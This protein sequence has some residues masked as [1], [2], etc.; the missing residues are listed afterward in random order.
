MVASHSHKHQAL[1]LCM[2]FSICAHTQ[3][4][5]EIYDCVQYQQVL[6]AGKE[7]RSCFWC[8]TS[9]CS[10]RLWVSNRRVAR[11][12]VAI[13]SLLCVTK[14]V[15]TLGLFCLLF[16]HLS[17][18]LDVSTRDSWRTALWS[19]SLGEWARM[20]AVTQHDFHAT[21]EDELSFQKS[22]IIKVYFRLCCCRHWQCTDPDHWSV[23]RYWWWMK[24]KAGL[25]LSRMA[26]LATYRRTT[27]SSSLIRK[28]LAM[29]CT[30]I[31]HVGHV[32]THENDVSD[33][34]N[35]FTFFD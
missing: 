3:D 8:S 4:K 24:N 11:A 17:C 9:E 29:C 10:S 22:S 16:I 34:S 18:D 27:S 13:R 33:L 26:V 25:K 14:K 7:T 31:S 20:E 1:L 23:C 6:C 32:T 2:L 15:F 35:S 19:N 21:A 28:C 12:R 30:A 5:V